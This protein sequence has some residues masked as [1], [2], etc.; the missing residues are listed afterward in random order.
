VINN[1][2]PDAKWINSQEIVLITGGSS[3]IG[4]LMA[5][6]FAKRGVKV[7]SLD[8]NPPKKPQRKSLTPESPNSTAVH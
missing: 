1:W 8:V 4:E 6:D 5:L 7:I 2:K 3:G